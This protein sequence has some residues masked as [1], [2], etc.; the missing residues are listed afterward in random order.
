[1][2]L[3][4]MAVSKI[5]DFQRLMSERLW[6]GK[7]PDE[8]GGSVPL[9]RTQNWNWSLTNASLPSPKP[10]ARLWH[11]RCRRS[12]GRSGSEPGGQQ[13]KEFDVEF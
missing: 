1:M 3:Q 10:T 8:G 7:E 9:F 11:E 6:Q 4:G 12:P 13:G 5:Q 2:A